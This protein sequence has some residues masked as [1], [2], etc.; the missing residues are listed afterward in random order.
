MR[1]ITVQAHCQPD[2]VPTQ[3]GS[4]AR[5]LREQGAS[6]RQQLRAPWL[7]GHRQVWAKVQKFRGVGGIGTSRVALGPRTGC[8]GGIEAH[9]GQLGVIVHEV[10]TK[11]SPVVEPFGVVLQRNAVL[12]A[13]SR[14]HI[15]EAVDV[16]RGWRDLCQWTV[17]QRTHVVRVVRGPSERDMH[18]VSQ[19]VGPDVDK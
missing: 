14:I 4:N 5:P 8:I 6:V 12:A 16:E 7:E 2:E 3:V 10:G 1:G 15:R 17:E 13:V 9:V 19:I 18:G 11:L